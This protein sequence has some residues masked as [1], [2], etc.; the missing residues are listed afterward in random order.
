MPSTSTLSHLMSILHNLPEPAIRPA[1]VLACI[2][3]YML[4]P[5]SLKVYLLYVRSFHYLDDRG[6]SVS[7]SLPHVSFAG[8]FGPVFIVVL[9]AFRGEQRRN[10]SAAED[11]AKRHNVPRFYTD[12]DDLLKDPEVDAVYVATPPG[13]H[14]ELALQ[15]CAAGK[16]CYM[17]KPMA[18]YSMYCRPSCGAGG[19][20]SGGY[21][22]SHPLLAAVRTSTTRSRKGDRIGKPSPW[23]CLACGE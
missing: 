13:S 3:L 2:Y 22:F 1:P 16:P 20:E 15:V 5:S 12:M 9:V 17:E 8:P 14:K 23:A 10:R 19:M 6:L 21:S 7:S 11:F 18:R 4:F